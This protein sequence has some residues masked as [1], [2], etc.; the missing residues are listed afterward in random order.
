MGLIGWVFFRDNP[1]ECGLQMDGVETVPSEPISSN[2]E[3]VKILS[4][5]EFTRG[6][7]LR[8]VAFWATS[9]ALSSQALV[10]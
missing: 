6:E 7:A 9:M 2:L 10:S 4:Q 3:P 5:R 8:T 1:E